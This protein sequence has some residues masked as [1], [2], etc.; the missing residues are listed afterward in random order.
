MFVSLRSD[1]PSLPSRLRTSVV[2][3]GLLL[4]LGT[5]PSAHAQNLRGGVRVGPA[6]GFLNDSAVPFVSTPGVTEAETNV[7]IDLNAGAHLVIPLTDRFSLQPEVLFVQKG[8]HLG[9]T[10][11][12][13]YTSERYRL[14]YVQTHLLG[15]R[16]I[17]ISS[18][19]SLHVLGGLTGALATGGVVRRNVRTSTT[20]TSERI[21]LLDAGLIRRWDLGVLVGGGLGYPVGPSSTLTLSLRYNP[22]VRTVFTDN[23]R[24]TDEQSTFGNEPPP[25]TR[26]P[27]PLRHDV[28]LVSI[29]YTTAL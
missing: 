16:D 11:F 26:T 17:R 27:P 24:P 4:L 18:P 12:S 23:E 21:A 10:G 20:E 6:F 3:V 29:A 13:S 5:L 7:R 14:S 28:I 2:A 22:G 15:R 19:L 9:R 1:R 25:L 8:A